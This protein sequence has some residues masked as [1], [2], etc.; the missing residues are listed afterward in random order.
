MKHIFVFSTGNCLLNTHTQSGRR[1]AGL[2]FL[3]V[4]QGFTPVWWYN[5][6]DGFG[7]A[8]YGTGGR[9]RLVVC[10]ATLNTEHCGGGAS[11]ITNP[12]NQHKWVGWGGVRYCIGGV[13]H[14]YL[15]FFCSCYFLCFATLVKFNNTGVHRTPCLA[16]DVNFLFWQMSPK[17]K[18]E[19]HLQQNKIGEHSM[20]QTLVEK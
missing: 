14:W 15:F 10:P 2:P 17:L 20:R 16:A 13:M 12:S 1:H 9:R 18:S 4:V 19:R 6:Y 7:P 5:T 8:A 3:A 11:N